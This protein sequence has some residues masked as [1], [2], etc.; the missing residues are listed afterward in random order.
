MVLALSSSCLVVMPAAVCRCPGRREP[1]FYP[2]V[3]LIRGWVHAGSAHQPKELCR[4]GSFARQSV[5]SRAPFLTHLTWDKARPR[6]PPR[7][8]RRLQ[9]FTSCRAPVPRRGSEGVW[10]CRRGGP[11]PDGSSWPRESL[12]PLAGLSASLSLRQDQLSTSEPPALRG[13]GFRQAGLGRK[14]GETLPP[15]AHPCWPFH[16]STCSPALPL[17]T[18]ESSES[19][20]FWCEIRGL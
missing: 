2:S 10:W 13:R 6:A 11:R 1:P 8:P 16:L 7:P 3:S 15:E 19:F 18:G 12:E 4:E 5:R 17:T 20:A 9:A 14:P